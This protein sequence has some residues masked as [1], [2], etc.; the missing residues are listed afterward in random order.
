MGERVKVSIG[1]EGRNGGNDD[2]E[3]DEDDDNDDNDDNNADEREKFNKLECNAYED[4][5]NVRE[6][7]V[8]DWGE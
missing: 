7:V 6:D 3:R 4:V 2:N 8:S 1:G 5:F